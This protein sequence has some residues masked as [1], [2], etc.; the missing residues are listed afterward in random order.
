M[1][2][3][4]AQPNGRADAAP[5][6]QQARAAPLADEPSRL[7]RPSI[8]V[9]NEI[10]QVGAGRSLRG[11]LIETRA[12]VISLSFEYDEFRVRASDPGERVF[13]ALGGT[14]A[15]KRR[16]RQAEQAARMLLESFGVVELE[17]LETYAVA[18]DCNAD[19]VVH[20]EGDA[21]VQCAFT[22]H[23]LPQL[24]A[25]G[26]DV[27]VEAD[28]PY[29]VLAEAPWYSRIEPDD[30][31]PDW[32]NLELGIEV[33]GHR[34]DLLPVLLSTLEDAGKDVDLLRLERRGPCFVQ[35]P[36]QGGY[37]ELPA[38]Q[39]RTLVRVLHE[40]YQGGTGGAAF[41]AIRVP[42]VV[43]LEQA[44]ERAGVVLHNYGARELR[45]RAHVLAALTS[46]ADTIA[47]PPVAMPQLCATLRPYQ[48]QGFAW[49]QKLRACDAGAVLADDMGLGK[50][51]QTIAHLC[52]EREAGTDGKPSLVVAP[53]S[54]IGNWRRELE[55]FA[56]H[57]QV[58]V[59]FGNGRH[60]RRT[61][62]A[63]ADVALTS[64]SVLLRDSEW[65]AEQ[66]FHC[67]VLDEAQ[68]IKNPRSRAAQ[69]VKTLD[70]VQPICLSG[71]PVENNLHELWSI[72]DFAMPGLLGSEEQFR[73]F[74]RIPIEQNRDEARLHALRDQV[75][76][77]L[78]RRMKEH[79]ARELPPKTEVVRP[80]E[81][82]GKQRELYES[83]RVAAHA[84]V[85]SALRKNGLQ[86]STVTILAALTRLRQLCC[87]PRLVHGEAAREVQESAKYDLLM[88]LLREQRAQGR[89]ALVFSQF[90]SMLGL[91][92]RG[93]RDQGIAHAC[94]TGATPD[95]DK[96]VR[97][98]ESGAVDVFLISLKAGGT[99]LNLISAD[100]VIH[101][102]P[103]WNPAAQAQAT[104][105]AHR[106]GQQKP[107]FVYNL[108]AA[109]SVE[110]RMLGLQHK[111]RR[112]AEAVVSAPAGQGSSGSVLGE[113]E[114]EH[115]LAP[116]DD[117]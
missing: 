60:A 39:F 98:F 46:E 37:V 58:C 31:K 10:L 65:L 13:C 18:P 24:R 83:I 9:W 76:P 67:V 80:V 61:Q 66:Q 38:E 14:I 15:A 77:Y 6:A 44:F 95:R 3:V 99:G 114:V 20:P 21:Q 33:G 25:L 100:T 78:M 22:A 109:G 115:L 91:I 107:V 29:R 89:R 101:Y 88:E 4:L 111:K 19:Y 53:T 17:L 82:R 93:L 36:E 47:L 30:E 97:A 94:L 57:L 90:A 26:W 64:Y 117:D 106:I 71:T 96:P 42:A 50:T 49:L 116:L 112:L 27:R 74:Y 75:A 113:A 81:L 2:E 41:P 23:A 51:L 28:F 55:R 48:A 16:D 45:A 108:I 54:L 68:A 59:L 110:E 12:P 63:A 72:F 52:A 62:L 43:G 79:V 7:V 84:K 105:R 8:R 104:D 32:F 86:G 1:R 56:P 70:C 40:L 92:S 11:D 85:R 102:D 73:H 87:D 5:G 34:I 35:V 69:L 103:W